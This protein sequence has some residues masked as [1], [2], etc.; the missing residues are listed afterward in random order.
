M[1]G[2]LISVFANQRQFATVP[3]A[4]T[5]G[6]ATALTY[7][8][9]SVTFTAPASDG[10]SPITSYTVTSSPGS[11]T[12]TGASSPI[13]V[14]GLSATTSYTFTVTA[15]NSVGTGPASSASNSITTPAAPPST[16][17]Q[18]YGGGY[19][20]GQIGV[21]STATH[22]LIVGPVA[23][24]QSTKQWKTTKT[25][26]TGTS[27]YID[28]PT[29]SSNMNNASHPAAEFCEALTIGGYSD[30]YMPARNE[31]EVCYYNL[32]PNTTT[33]NTSSGINAN[34]VP[35]RTSNY[36]TG[37]PAQTSAAAFKDTGAEDYSAAIYW[38][39]TENVNFSGKYAFT[40]NFNRG[41]Q[42]EYDKDSS[43]LVR[44]IR[45]IA[46]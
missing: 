2:A 31:L 9:A 18:S 17:G 41:Q 22:Y 15:T 30:W 8:T 28:G 12:G 33:N 24:A 34:S 39:S 20:A 45:R 26:T 19:Y 36:T 40:Q 21:S 44:A 16:I 38:S 5:I 11:Y 27:S 3:G 35:E 1:S 10:G 46:V 25:A 6:T 13:T 29:N 7:Q 42:Q 23:S 4:P 14:S 43:Q 37:T 32:K